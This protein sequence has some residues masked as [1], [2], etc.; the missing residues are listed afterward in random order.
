MFIQCYFPFDIRTGLCLVRLHHINKCKTQEDNRVPM[1]RKKN[2]DDLVTRPSIHRIDPH[3]VQSNKCIDI[4]VSSSFWQQNIEELA[5]V[6]QVKMRR[7]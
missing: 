6:H 7:S 5:S 2:E 4:S 1:V 3:S